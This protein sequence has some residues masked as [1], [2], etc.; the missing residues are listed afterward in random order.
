MR[1]EA[2]FLGVSILALIS[3]CAA[4]GGAETERLPRPSQCP[5]LASVDYAGLMRLADPA[6][7]TRVSQY[8]TWAREQ[9]EMTPLPDEARAATTRIRIGLPPTGMWR[10]DNRITLWRD[11]AGAWFVSR[12]DQDLGLPPP[13][14]Q[15][16]PYPT[17][18]GWTPPPP[19]SLEE[20]FP[21]VTGPVAPVDAQ[22][23]EAALADPC[24]RLE[25]NRFTSTIPMRGT[26]DWVCVPDSSSWAAEIV[27]P[28]RPARLIA[29]ACQNDLLTSDLLQQASSIQ[30]LGPPQNQ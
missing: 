20:R 18:E 16:P 26:H 2:A 1:L 24:L 5:A 23:L 13:P 3:A 6:T 8:D 21:V 29:I 4:A 14:P 28:G 30:P 25:P 27:E 19:P 22:R 12:R 10:L 17:P 7:N 11:A 15:P 9:V